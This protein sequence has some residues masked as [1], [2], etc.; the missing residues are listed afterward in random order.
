V[1]L[2]VA[3]LSAG[4]NWAVV[5]ATMVIVN[6]ANFS[7]KETLSHPLH[8]LTNKLTFFENELIG[9]IKALGP[10]FGTLSKR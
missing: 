8:F 5:V 4:G 3:T 7:I 9:G 1:I 6:A 10:M 2:K